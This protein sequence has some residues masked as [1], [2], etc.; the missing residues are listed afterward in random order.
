MRGKTRRVFARQNH[1]SIN[2]QQLSYSRIVPDVHCDPLIVLIILI[3]DA[4]RKIRKTEFI[5]ICGSKNGSSQSSSRLL[6]YE[7]CQLSF[8]LYKAFQNVH[9]K[10]TN[11]VIFYLNFS[12]FINFNHYNFNLTSV[13]HNFM[14]IQIHIALLNIKNILFWLF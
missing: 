12:T 11:F 14:L 4:N 6:L 9:F 8:C 5:Y 2:M 1:D 3:K 13:K 7:M 10:L